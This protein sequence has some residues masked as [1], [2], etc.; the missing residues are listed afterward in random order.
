MKK[1]TISGFSKLSKRGKLKWIAENF[2]K[3]PEAVKNE[4]VSF[5]HKDESQQ[6]IL[7]GFSE[8]TLSNYPMPYGAAPNYL[9]ND[10]VYCIPM[11]TEESSVVAAAS[12]AGK[13]WL[14]RGG[15]K[16]TVIN[17]RKIGQLYFKSNIGFNSLIELKDD[18]E[19]ALRDESLEYCKNMVERG[20]GILDMEFIDMNSHID[21]T[22]QLRVYF[23]T[24]DSMGANFINTIM[25]IYG[26]NLPYILNKLSGETVNTDILMAILSNYTPECTVKAE[27]SC[28]IADLDCAS[29]EMEKEEF[30][31]RFYDAVKLAKVDPYRATTHNKGIFNGIDAV[32]LA[33]GNDFRAIEAGGHA[34][35]ARNG[36]YAS[37][38]DCTI[39]D[40]I[41]RF[42]LEIPLAL[43]T[44]GGLTAL[45]PMAKRSLE[46]LG[47]PT[48]EE[49]MMIVASV[50]LGQN[51]AA[52][53]SL[54]TTGIQHGHMKMHLHNILHHLKANDAELEKAEEYF[55]DKVVSFHSV[56][57]FLSNERGTTISKN[58]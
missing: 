47:S 4:L 43:G 27:V 42:W 25:E 21:N 33:T 18:I 52:I 10:K 12:Y 35:A 26:E 46:L 15:F 34:Y 45:H 1:K 32:I 8:N 9:V 36:T 16:A 5:W 44:V 22:Y 23:D 31:Q 28:P 13:F 54:V 49:L 20:G 56:R 3:D 48:A 38:S 51:F 24:R 57:E 14:N 39:D 53:K 17:T 7:D 2:F 41:F 11:V 37:L 29:E 30:A 6:K 50:G 40:G 19:S 58:I 55:K